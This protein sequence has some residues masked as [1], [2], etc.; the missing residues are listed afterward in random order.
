MNFN[1]WETTGEAKY[2]Q[3]HDYIM[4]QWRNNTDKGC[5]L[6]VA[7]GK[8]KNAN[9]AAPINPDDPPAPKYPTYYWGTYG[10]A[11]QI[12]EWAQLTGSSKAADLILSFGD[13]HAM[14]Q[15]GPARCD[16]RNSDNR[17][18]VGAEQLY[19][20]YEGIVPAYALLRGKTHPERVERWKKA[21]QWRLLD[22]PYGGS[23]KLLARG[24]KPLPP[25]DYTAKNWAA[26]RVRCY[27]QNGHKIFAAQAMEALYTLWLMRPEDKK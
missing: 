22:Y 20:S 19:R 25:E 10:G 7:T 26:T 24:A 21:M 2:A 6:V 11:S 5:T 18:G 8:L 1:R 12:S 17:Q 3:Y 9:G 27:G 14:D 16:I 4:E 15:R 23:P 13:Y